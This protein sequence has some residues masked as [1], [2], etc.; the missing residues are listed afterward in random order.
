MAKK[1]SRVF[2]ILQKQLMQEHKKK[3]IT[4]ITVQFLGE[5]RWIPMFQVIGP[6]GE[7]VTCSLRVQSSQRLRTWASLSSLADWLVKELAVD[8]CEVHLQPTNNKEGD[9]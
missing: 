7:L 5:K 2:L 6:T 1:K 8:V 4:K 9:S 3:R